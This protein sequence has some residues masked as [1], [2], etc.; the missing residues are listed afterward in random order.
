M[1]VQ[2]LRVRNYKS[3]DD[4]GWVDVDDVTCI[5]GKNESGKTVFME[6][7][8]RLNPSY[9]D[10]EYTPY[11]DY[12]RRRWP[13]YKRRHDEEPDPVASARLE[14][15]DGEAEAVADAFGGLE[16][17][18]VVVTKYYDNERRWSV[19]VDE[20]AFVDHLVSEHDVPAD[21]AGDLR[22]AGT[23]SEL[24]DAVEAADA[25]LPDLA[26][27]VEAHDGELAQRAGEEVLAGELPEFRYVGEYSI[28]DGTIDVDEIADRRDRAAFNTS[29]RIFLS[30]LSVAG[31]DLDAVR[32]TDDWRDVLTEL[33]AASGE[34]TGSVMEYWSQTDDL[35]MHIRGGDDR[36]LSLRVENTN[37]NVTVEFE[38][39]SRGFRWFFSTFCQVY[40]LR[41][42]GNDLVLLLDEPGLHLHPRAKEEF[43]D[44]LEATLVPDHTLVYST[45]SPFMIQTE[46]AHETKMMQKDPERGSTVVTD[47]S[48]ADAFTRFPL[49]NVFELDVMDTLL[50]RSQVVLVRDQ[51]THAYL[52]NVSELL[53]VAGERGL[54]YRWTVLP[55]GA[56]ENVP[57]FLSLFERNDLDAAVLLEGETTSADEIPETVAVRSVEEYA[58]VGGAATIEDVLSERFYLGLVSRAYAGRLSAA[59][60]VPDR[61]TPAALSA[62]VGD[63]PI[64]ERVET[65]FETHGLGPFDRTVPA[66][67]L[68]EH[69]EEFGAELDMET[70]RS[71]GSLVTAFDRILD[72]VSEPTRSE[73]SF[74][75]RLFGG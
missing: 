26:E 59:P 20:S 68:Q 50:A 7:V 67:Y 34:I 53:E 74:V 10:G 24:A 38:Q 64:V 11:D 12:P 62:D 47:P 4:T 55:V 9:G 69:R 2:Q 56:M 28:M 54:D 40:D 36:T 72:S 1:N 46:R 42:S 71:F 3:I 29:D 19:D 25:D 33:E 44:F 57:T 70:K 13:E 6:A 8:E 58:D 51:A 35:K 41:S 66:S 73:G 16:S 61:L 5:I 48:D 15:D 49:E 65:Y 23:L 32:E 45:H 43:V 22:T 30:L 31:L 39:R 37:H 18:T 21:A 52:Y 60:E 14:L 75:S 63:G 17:R 27:A